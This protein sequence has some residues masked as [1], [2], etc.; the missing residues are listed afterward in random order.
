MRNLAIALDTS[1]TTLSL[2]NG[3]RQR[4]NALTCLFCFGPS[5]YV[6]AIHNVIQPSRFYLF[7]IAGCAVSVDNSWPSIVLLYIWPPVLCLV[8]SYYCTLII[9]RLHRYRK[10][11]AAILMAAN[12]GLTKSRFLRLFL[13]AFILLMVYLPIQFYVLYRNLA[14][15]LQ[16]YSWSRIHGPDWNTIMMIPTGGAVE[17]DR[18]IRIS[19]GFV[20][21]ACFGM[22]HEASIMYRSWLLS[23]GLGFVFPGLRCG[24]SKQ[25]SQASPTT[26]SSTRASLSKPRSFATRVRIFFHQKFSLSSSRSSTTSTLPLHSPVIKKTNSSRLPS[27]DEAKIFVLCVKPNRRPYPQQSLLG[28]RR[29]QYHQ[30]SYP[31]LGLASGHLPRP[32]SRT[33]F[34][35]LQDCHYRP[36][37]ATLGVCCGCVALRRTRHFEP[38]KCGSLL[39]AV[40]C[41]N[42][43]LSFFPYNSTGLLIEKGRG[44]GEKGDVSHGFFLIGSCNQVNSQSIS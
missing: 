34:C 43:E 24:Q 10:N 15:P 25:F 28:D 8:D 9:I 17:F 2:T 37:A 5:I 14:F 38:P 33:C 39:W 36:T 41:A 22:G 32:Q 6:A 21:F 44:G 29:E 4:R 20:V 42:T 35:E 23:C 3:E 1:K 26:S 7:A 16:P 12:S 11:F 40:S 13:M 30:P 27:I 18:W 31:R 19:L